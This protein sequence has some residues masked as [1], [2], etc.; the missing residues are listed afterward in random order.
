MNNKVIIVTLVLSAVMFTAPLTKIAVK[1]YDHAVAAATAPALAPAI[2]VMSEAERLQYDRQIQDITNNYERHYHKKLD[3]FAA[4]L[5]DF[6]CRVEKGYPPMF[7]DGDLI[8]YICPAKEV[9]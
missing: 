3:Q 8:E 9:K 5:L 1:K 2:Q 4:V 7:Q 6:G